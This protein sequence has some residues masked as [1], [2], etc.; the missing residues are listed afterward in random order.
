MS[1]VHGRLQKGDT[2]ASGKIQ[3]NSSML[4]L[5]GMIEE[6]SQ[7]ALQSE[8]DSAKRNSRDVDIDLAQT[9]G[10]ELAAWR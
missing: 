8:L 2:V 10:Y 6:A 7:N 5:K 4:F 3:A 1:L 9:M